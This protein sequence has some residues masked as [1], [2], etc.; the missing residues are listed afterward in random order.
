MRSQRSAFSFR[1]AT[2]LV[3]MSGP[4][5]TPRILAMAGHT[6]RHSN[7]SPL[8]ILNASF[9]AWGDCEAQTIT[10]A[11]RS[12]SAASQTNEGPPG[13]PNGSP[14]SRRIAAYTPIA[15]RTFNAP[16]VGQVTSCGRSAV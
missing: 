2:T 15:G 13:K 3:G 4:V 8:V 10:S 14:F 5:S 11:T 6:F 1:Y 16:G 12:A 9:D 7:T